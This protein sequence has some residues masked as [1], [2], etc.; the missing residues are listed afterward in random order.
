MS[1]T[2]SARLHYPNPLS[3]VKGENA[4]FA[5]GR[6]REIEGVSLPVRERPHGRTPVRV[7]TGAWL[8]DVADPRI[9]T[10]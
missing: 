8:P 10:A 7:P 3:L 5:Q 1:L 2:S 6:E 9:S 4:N